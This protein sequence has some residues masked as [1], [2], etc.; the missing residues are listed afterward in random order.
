MNMREVFLRIGSFW[1]RRRAWL[2][3]SLFAAFSLGAVVGLTGEWSSP[4]QDTAPV[5][6]AAIPFSTRPW[7]T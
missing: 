2:I 7:L 1:T 4:G 5:I 3:A 6:R